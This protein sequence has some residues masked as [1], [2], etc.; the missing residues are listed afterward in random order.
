M[1]TCC[2]SA[3]VTIDPTASHQGSA[4]SGLHAVGLLHLGHP[5]RDH[6][7]DAASH[8]GLATGDHHA[9]I[10]IHHVPAWT[11]LHI[12]VHHGPALCGFHFDIGSLH[13]RGYDYQF[14]TK[15]LLG[16]AQNRALTK[17]GN[18]AFLMILQTS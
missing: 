9:T 14:A 17:F 15:E 16:N 11:A 18:R 12:T 7:A 10:A 1:F 5:L 2:C 4:L 3:S 8:Q 6:H 13:C